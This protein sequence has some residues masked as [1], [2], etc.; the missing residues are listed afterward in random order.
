MGRFEDRGT[1]K[2]GFLRVITTNIEGCERKV[3]RGGCSKGN[4]KGGASWKGYRE[5]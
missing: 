4:L 3:G 1:Q 2:R 5:K